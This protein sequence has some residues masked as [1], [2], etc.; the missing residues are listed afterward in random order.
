MKS[1]QDFYIPKTLEE[2]YP[3][4][5]NIFSSIEYSDNKTIIDDLKSNKLGAADFHFGVGTWIRNKWGLWSGS[6]LSKYFNDIG[7]THADDMYSIIMDS[8]IAKLK[9][10]EF[11]LEK[12]VSYY[13]K[14]WEDKK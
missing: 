6:E 14:Y 3:E 7:I 8:Y 5:D 11:D 13:Q 10:E 4:L 2:C 9:G 1:E 12:A